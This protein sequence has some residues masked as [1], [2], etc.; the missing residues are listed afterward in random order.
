VVARC[1]DRPSARPRGPPLPSTTVPIV[2]DD[3]V[4]PRHT[5]VLTCA[6]QRGVIGDLATNPSLRAEAEAADLAGHVLP[7][8]RAARGAGVRI[9]HNTYG[10]RAHLAGVA[11][12]TSMMGAAIKAPRR[13]LQ[14]KPDAD[15]V[16]AWRR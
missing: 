3:L 2:F 7:L 10:I 15:V 5:A 13:I 12:N 11:V 9:V 16:D 8:L 1:Q 4:A 6:V 14:G